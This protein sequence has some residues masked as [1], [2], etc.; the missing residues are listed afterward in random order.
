MGPS[1]WVTS[2]EDDLVVHVDL[3][4]RKVVARIPVS[5]PTGIAAGLGGVWVVEHRGDSLVRIDP[6]TNDVVAQIRLGDRGPNELCGMCVEN[7]IVSDGS[8]WTSNN[9]ARS[10]SRIDAATNELVATIDLPLRVWAVTAGGG[11]IWASQFQETPDGG[12]GDMSVAR[13]DPATNQPSSFA[14]DAF[15][16]TWAGD[17]LWAVT[18]GRRGDV[19][20]RVEPGP[21]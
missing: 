2:F 10:V 11:A 20:V 19:V 6:K 4:T 15:S 17:A 1:L 3:S 5:K 14:L 12:F 13:I 8:V 21:F 9:E 16:V 18:P 7:V